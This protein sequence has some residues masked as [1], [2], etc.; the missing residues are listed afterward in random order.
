MTHSE[1]LEAFFE[2]TIRFER[3]IFMPGALADANSLAQDLRDWLEEEDDKTILQAFPKFP[4]P[5]RDEKDC[6]L[7]F[8]AEWLI[9]HQRL[10][11]LVQVATPVMQHSKSNKSSIFSWGYYSTRWVYGE[12]MDEVV[13]KAI[14]W[15][16]KRREFEK[17]E[18]K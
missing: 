14:A 4:L 6:F 8:A 11:F 17:S 7:E 9:D 16:N 3:V 15:A 18:A 2:N 12:T 10:G 5:L 1:I 13:S